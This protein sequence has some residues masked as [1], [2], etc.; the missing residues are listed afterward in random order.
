ML[1]SLT[2]YEEHRLLDNYDRGRNIFRIHTSF[3]L[4]TFDVDLSLV[5]EKLKSCG[6][7][8]STLPSTDGTM[9]TSID[10]DLLYGTTG[11]AEELEQL[12]ENYSINIVLL[13]KKPLAEPETIPP[14]PN[15]SLPVV[16]PA[17]QTMAPPPASINP[18]P[19]PAGG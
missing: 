9:D 4:T 6:E 1:A 11:E 10:F 8:I 12:V 13:G 5:S 18:P 7:I 2:E 16:S 15:L 19:A 14:E 17:E 3:D